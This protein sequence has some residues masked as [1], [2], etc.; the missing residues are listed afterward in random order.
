[1]FNERFQNPV[2][3]FNGDLAGSHFFMAPTAMFQPDGY[4]QVKNYRFLLF[5]ALYMAASAFSIRESTSPASLGKMLIP[6]LDEM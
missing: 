2:S 3:L 5:L 4:S 1:M 6:M